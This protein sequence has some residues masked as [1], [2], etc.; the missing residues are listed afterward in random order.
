MGG[1]RGFRGLGGGVL[2]R[3]IMADGGMK[4]GIGA[5]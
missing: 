4:G 2:F 1:V 3:S 5:I